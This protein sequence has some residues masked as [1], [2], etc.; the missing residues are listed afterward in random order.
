MS[1]TLTAKASKGLV[2]VGKTGEHWMLSVE[3]SRLLRAELEKAEEEAGRRKSAFQEW[4][5][6]PGTATFEECWNA[7]L[8]AGIAAMPGDQSYEI[9]QLRALKEPVE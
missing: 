8:D 4:L 9:D 5:E 7:A 3:E 6:K 1:T 2:E